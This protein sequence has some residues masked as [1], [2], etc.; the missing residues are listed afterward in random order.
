[1]SE[2][3]CAWT[4]PKLG[5]AG[6]CTDKAFY[7]K[8]VIAY[9]VKSTFVPTYTTFLLEATFN[10]A[11]KA[12]TVFPVKFDDWEWAD[13]EAGTWTS[14]TGIPYKTTA[15][16]HIAVM[17]INS[18][19]CLKSELLK[20]E[21]FKG[22]VMLGYDQ[23]YIRGCTITSDVVIGMRIDKVMFMGEEQQGTN[24]E[25]PAKLVFHIIFTTSKDFSDYEYTRE[26]TWVP[27][28]IDGIHN[29][30]ITKISSGTSS[31][32]I[33]ISVHIDCDGSYVPV[34]G[35][36][37]ADLVSTMGAI[38]SCTESTSTAGNYTLVPTTTWATGTITLAGT[39][40][41]T[42][43]TMALQSTGAV[44]ITI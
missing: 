12:E 2:T 19:L 37:V 40:A 10:T 3:L 21:G 28:D 14:G 33:V 16:K 26:M 27:S 1:M 31:T 25:D 35:L 18:S 42:Y 5:R 6:L 17:K 29:A 24:S 36:V 30:T 44:S 11:V 32:A 15:R 4:S 38:A 7:G 34:E 43:A 23:Q 8:P 20:L 9:F 22:G 39:T 13:V 41:L